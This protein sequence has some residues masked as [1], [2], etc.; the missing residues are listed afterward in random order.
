M[1]E[2][3]VK[4]LWIRTFLNGP[5][6]G[7]GEYNGN[8]VWFSRVPDTDNIA[9]NTF[10]LYAVTDQQYD[11]FLAERK[12][13]CEASGEP[14]MHGDVEVIKITPLVVKAPEEPAAGLPEAYVESLGG[15]AMQFSYSVNLSAVVTV[16]IEEITIDRFSNMFVPHPVRYE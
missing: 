3:K 13:Y 9:S 8:K 15:V 12:R 1:A 6:D 16:P 11:E 14:L 7:M 4:I 2:S 10:K 5:A